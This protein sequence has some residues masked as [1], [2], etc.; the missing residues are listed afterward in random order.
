MKLG[1]RQREN[2]LTDKKRADGEGE[3]HHLSRVKAFQLITDEH[4]G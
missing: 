4:L 1:T 2:T 3:A